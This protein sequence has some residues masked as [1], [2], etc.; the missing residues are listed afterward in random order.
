MP[1]VGMLYSDGYQEMCDL[2]FD[3]A[4]VSPM[5][6]AKKLKVFQ[7]EWASQPEH[8][9]TTKG[10]L[11]DKVY[12]S[13]HQEINGILVLAAQ[14]GRYAAEKCDM[15]FALDASP[16]AE[17]VFSKKAAFIWAAERQ[18][19]TL[20]KMFIANKVDLELYYYRSGNAL[21][22][23]ARGSLDTV[24][25]LVE[26]KAKIDGGRDDCF[27]NALGV[28]VANNKLDI[29]EYLVRS[30]ADINDRRNIRACAAMH[31][32]PCTHTKCKPNRFD[33]VCHSAPRV[34][35]PG[36][37]INCNVPMILLLARLGANLRLTCMARS[38]GPDAGN[39]VRRPIRFC[40][41]A[42]KELCAIA[43]P[44]VVARRLAFA[45]ALHRRLGESAGVSVIL[46]EL[47]RTV[48]DV[49]SSSC[50]LEL[51]P[52]TAA[53]FAGILNTIQ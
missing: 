4:K 19:T 1:I 41:E 22:C 45:M 13:Q 23:A 24:K 10:T 46:T 50:C 31:H 49:P 2:A 30:G 6:F 21:T 9:Q 33:N 32:T 17:G 35:K 26:A 8:N 42:R 11:K 14:C 36:E 51:G 52:V 44:R 47:F 53:L 39:L 15:L 37:F 43:R 27:R 28:A 25:V 40:N 48:A 29:V 3:K 16:N 38:E 12:A 5:E 20:V 18:D 34:P 7:A